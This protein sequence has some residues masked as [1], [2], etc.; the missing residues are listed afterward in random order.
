MG[1]MEPHPVVGHFREILAAK[2]FDESLSV[3]AIK[4]LV[5]VIERSTDLTMMGLQQELKGAQQ[6]LLAYADG[7]ALPA[8]G[9]GSTLPLASGCELFVRYISR[10]LI[11]GDFKVA[12]SIFRFCPPSCRPTLGCQ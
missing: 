11:L 5:R 10:T 3:V 9:R 4:V 1:E 12:R 2:D 8:A 7:T 6:A